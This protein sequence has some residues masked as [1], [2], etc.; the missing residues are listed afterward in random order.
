MQMGRF[1]IPRTLV[2]A[3]T[4]MGECKSDHIT[5]AETSDIVFF[6]ACEDLCY[7]EPRWVVR[8]PDAIVLQDGAPHQAYLQ[9]FV[10][11]FS[12]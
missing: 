7:R 10:L 12:D 1:H 3:Q 2:R 5:S 9:N 8:G 4:R 6:F 11:A